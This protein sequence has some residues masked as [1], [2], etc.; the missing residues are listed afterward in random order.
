VVIDLEV[1]EYCCEIS[2]ALEIESY[3]RQI[4]PP[5]DFDAVADRADRKSQVRWLLQRVSAA[6]KYH[7][8]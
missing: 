7:D 3:L 6:L 8:S 2:D 4:R 5:F 1:D